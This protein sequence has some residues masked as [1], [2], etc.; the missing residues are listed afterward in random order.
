MAQSTADELFAEVQVLLEAKDLEQAMKKLDEVLEIDPE[1]QQALATRIYLNALAVDN[2]DQVIK[3]LSNFAKLNEK[4]SSVYAEIGYLYTDNEKYDNALKL[5]NIAIPLYPEAYNL[6]VIRGIANKNKGNI[7][8]AIADYEKALSINPKYEYALNLLAK[9]RFEAEYT[10]GAMSAIDEMLKLNPKSHLAYHTRSNFYSEMEEYDKALADIQAALSHSKEDQQL[11]AYYTG[12]MAFFY[13][14]MGDANKAYETALAAKSMG[15]GTA[16][17]LIGGEPPEIREQGRLSVGTAVDDN[18]TDIDDYIDYYGISVAI[19]NNYAIIGAGLHCLTEEKLNEGA[20]YIFERNDETWSQT[21]KLTLEDAAEKD[22]F[23]YSVAID[24]DYAVVGAPGKKISHPY[25]GAAYV[26]KR[27]GDNWFQQAR[28]TASNPEEDNM[29]ASSVA[30]SGNYIIVGTNQRRRAWEEE[31]TGAAY[32]FRRNGSDWIEQTKLVSE[33]AEPRDKFGHTVDIDGDCVVVGAPGHSDD[34]IPEGV[35]GA[36]YVFKQE[37]NLWVQ[38]VKFIPDD[39]ET[40]ENFAHSVAIGGENIVVSAVDDSGDALALIYQQTEHTWVKKTKLSTNFSSSSP[41]GPVVAISNDY[42][43]FG[44]PDLASKSVNAFKR[45]G[46]ILVEEPQLVYDDAE[47]QVKN[48]GCSIATSNGY[49]IVGSGKNS[50]S[51]D[52]YPDIAYIFKMD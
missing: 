25:E 49:I 3:D 22:F 51:P 14:D 27:D 43:V 29:F 46:T 48:F 38:Q 28:L 41:N 36:V 23:G 12:V 4:P 8:Q 40:S 37:D 35:E 24:G 9:A 16:Y 19:S 2:Y 50:E 42:V 26:F 21:T 44:T 45:S 30:I 47:S 33:D 20:V 7:K 6:Y 52:D 39:G 32:I 17:A 18:S 13:N 15:D 31:G 34:N 5:A 10:E 1:H 11:Q